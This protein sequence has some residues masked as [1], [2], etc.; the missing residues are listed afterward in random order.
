MI[1]LDPQEI[2]RT[3]ELLHGGELVEVRALG[4]GRK[5]ETVSGYF[6]DYKLAAESVVQLDGTSSPEGIYCNLQTIHPGAYARSPDQLNS[7]PRYTTSDRDITAYRWTLVDCDPVR[8]AGVSANDDELKAAETTCDN[9]LYFLREISE[10]DPPL[11]LKAFSGNGYHVLI[12]SDY[13]VDVGRDA[14]KG[15]LE[16]LAENFS[17]QAVAVDSSVFNPS[18]IVKLYGT[19]ARKGYSVRGHG[20]IYRKSFLFS[21]F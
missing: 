7:S 17:T 12:R 19:T 10:H 15:F 9:V 1:Q 8:P 3:L 14:I 21:D 2:E 4:C 20:R 5:R 16:R 11:M 13:P 18:R 6:L